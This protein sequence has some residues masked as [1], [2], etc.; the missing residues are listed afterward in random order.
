MSLP[1]SS[2]EGPLFRK[3]RADLYTALLFIALVAMILACVVAYLEV[4]DYGDSPYQGGPSVYV[5][6]RESAPLVAWPAPL[7][8]DECRISNV[9]T[10]PNGE[11]PMA[12]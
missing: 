6:P 12:V 2:N 11:A 4:K 8:N 9:D 5:V 3:P 7:E 1:N 10:K